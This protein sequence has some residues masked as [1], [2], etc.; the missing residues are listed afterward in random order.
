MNRDQSGTQEKTSSSTPNSSINI[1]TLKQQQILEKKEGEDSILSK[2]EERK[3]ELNRKLTFTNTQIHKINNIRVLDSKI[4][5]KL[6]L[7]S[8][9]TN[10]FGLSSFSHTLF[11]HNFEKKTKLRRM[12]NLWNMMIMIIEDDGNT[13]AHTHIQKHTNLHDSDFCSF[14]LFPS[15]FVHK[16]EHEPNL[17]VVVVVVEHTMNKERKRGRG[18]SAG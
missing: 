11:A 6:K 9:L 13:Y 14:F 8:T 15:C 10:R 4:L 3:K 2:E 18:R 16:F 7:F 12:K 17:I 5:D 1:S